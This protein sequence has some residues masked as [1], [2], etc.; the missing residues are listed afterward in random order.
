MEADTDLLLGDM[1]NS[2]VINHNMNLPVRNFEGTL[3]SHI[4]QDNF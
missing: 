1:M 4:L 2:D 3:A